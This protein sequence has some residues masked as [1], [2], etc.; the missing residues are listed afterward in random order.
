[1]NAAT[2]RD[3][4]NGV[5]VICYLRNP[6]LELSA[7]CYKKHNIWWVI[8]TFFYHDPMSLW[9][10]PVA[11]GCNYIV[12][13]LR[14]KVGESYPHTAYSKGDLT[15]PNSK[16][17]KTR[18]WSNSESGNITIQHHKRRQIPLAICLTWVAINKTWWN[19]VKSIGC[20]MKFSYEGNID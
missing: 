17:S 11:L 8:S 4:K 12:S 19:F 18:L 16:P 20:V 14:H 3:R 7:L 5:V 9:L 15:C 6:S 10:W 13:K 2:V 1:M